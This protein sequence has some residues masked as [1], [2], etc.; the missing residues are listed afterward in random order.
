MTKKSR[1]QFVIMSAELKENT[2][3]DNEIRT[4]LLETMLKSCEFKY[5]KTQGNFYN[6][7]EN[8]FFINVNTS[9]DVLTLQDFAFKN[10]DQASILYSD[11]NGQAYLEHLNGN[12]ERLGTLKEYPVSKIKYLDNYTI[13]NNKAYSTET[14]KE[15]IYCEYL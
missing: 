9:D 2:S 5:N 10:F 8:S 15:K 12:C 11:S 13:I 14:I 6:N 3:H 4:M 7:A 1:Q